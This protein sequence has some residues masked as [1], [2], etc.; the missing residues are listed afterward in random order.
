MLKGKWLSNSKLINLDLR[1][2]PVNVNYSRHFFLSD[3][4]DK[5][6]ISRR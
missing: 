4:R 3:L 1:K 6:L 2:K 5:H